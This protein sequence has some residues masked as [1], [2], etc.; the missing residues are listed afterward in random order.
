MARFDVFEF[1][2]QSVPLVLDAQADLL[3]DLNTRVVIPLSPSS[4]S[5]NE[6]LPRLKPVIEINDDRYVLLT[7]DIGTIL[8]TALGARVA[9]IENT[10]RQEIVDALDF[11]FQGF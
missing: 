11:L 2:N 6:A 4:V 9:N 8:K 5:M 3:A 7:T 10:H 1:D